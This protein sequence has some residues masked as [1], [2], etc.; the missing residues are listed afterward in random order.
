MTLALAPVLPTTAKVRVSPYVTSFMNKYA[1]NML[2][3]E[4]PEVFD[5]VYSE[6]LLALVQSASRFKSDRG[7]KITT[8]SFARVRGQVMRSVDAYFKRKAQR[9][10]ISIDDP[11]VINSGFDLGI[12]SPE[13]RYISTRSKGQLLAA[14]GKIIPIVCTPVQEYIIVASFF[15]GLSDEDIAAEIPMGLDKMRLEKRAT[16]EMLRRECA[17]RNLTL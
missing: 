6:A 17:R 14:L 13:H 10:T 3:N 9:P 8:Q 7:V 5:D 11:D 12:P 15:Q 1:R 2:S 16:L 4:P